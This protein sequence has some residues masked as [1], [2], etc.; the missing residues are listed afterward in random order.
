MMMMMRR[1]WSC[2]SC[3]FACLHL[4]PS[5]SRRSHFWLFGLTVEGPSPATASCLDLVTTVWFLVGCQPETSWR[6]HQS[7]WSLTGSLSYLRAEHGMSLWRV[8]VKRRND[9]SALCPLSSRPLALFSGLSL[10]VLLCPSSPAAVKVRTKRK[11]R[12]RR[13]MRRRRTCVV[14][15]HL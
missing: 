5:R 1:S 8:P 6:S 15:E 9:F 10:L 14:G 3:W 11:R 13:K 4:P 12:S 7:A 2:C